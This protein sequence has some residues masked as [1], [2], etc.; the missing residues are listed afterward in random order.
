MTNTLMLAIRKMPGGR[1]N[2]I[3][4]VRLAAMDS[5]EDAK[6]FLLC[7]DDL[8]P[9]HQK[10]CSFDDV[11]YASGVKIVDMLKMVTAIAFSVNVDIANFV[12]AM[13]HPDVVKASVSAAKRRGGYRDREML[14]SHHG[15]LPKRGGTSIQVNAS[16]RS[17]A[18][19]EAASQAAAAAA[20]EQSSLP[21]FRDEMDAL[22]T[23]R[24]TV[25]SHLLKQGRR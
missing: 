10:T 2:F 6:K 18:S 21:K 22:D 5:D 3:E 8:S 25:Q 15:F 12:A 23:V 7:F 9:T 20:A 17:D 24:S 16:S 13:S 14:M 4:Y 1:E 19:A 11:C